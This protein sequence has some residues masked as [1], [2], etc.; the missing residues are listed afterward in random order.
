MLLGQVERVIINPHNR[1]VIAFVVHGYFPE[2]KYA[3][4]SYLTGENKQPEQR[5]VLPIHSVRYETESSTMLNISSNEAAGHR[6]FD[7]VDFVSPAENWH[8]PYPYHWGDVL[9]E[10]ESKNGQKC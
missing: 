1:R 5:V 9:F 3:S 2:P 6:Y 4:E 8:P 7:A 10:K